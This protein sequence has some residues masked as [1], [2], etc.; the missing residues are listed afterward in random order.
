MS[1]FEQGAPED[2]TKRVDVQPTD[3]ESQFPV[4][5]FVENG[6]LYSDLA[7]LDESIRMLEQ[8]G[9]IFLNPEMADE[10][11]V[12]MPSGVLLHGPAGVGKT[13]LVK[14]FANDIKAQLINVSVSDILG[15]HVGEPN[16]R[17][18]KLFTSA[19]TRKDPVVLFFDEIDGLFS[20]NA[21]G[22]TGVNTSLVAE[23]KTLMSTL[24][25]EQQNTIVVGCTNKIDVFDESLIRPGRFDVVIPITLPDVECRQRI[26]SSYISR[27]IDLYK[28]GAGETLVREG[29]IIDLN[30]LAK[31][32]EGMTGADIESILHTARTSRL[33][34]RLQR[35]EAVTRVTQNDIQNAI[36][37]HRLS[38]SSGN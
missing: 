4:L 11:D 27:R 19:Q 17:L 20:K 28:I 22:N 34:A 30:E 35:N 3:V 9:T 25:R 12:Q 5:T 2:D 14:A 26:F 37:Q 33:V 32:T 1:E 38:R 15:G 10:Y 23:F 21:G 6:P 18:K 31:G 29:G 16:I 36:K 13:Q 24:R 8:V 7:G